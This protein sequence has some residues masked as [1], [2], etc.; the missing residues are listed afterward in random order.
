VGERECELNDRR[1]A[2]AAGAHGATSPGTRAG[3]SE[4]S[5][6]LVFQAP[7]SPNPGQFRT[8]KSTEL[9]FFSFSEMSFFKGLHRLL[10]LHFSFLAPAA[11]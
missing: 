8:G 2:V 5:A 3:T 1:V 7:N 10:G 6:D 9:T 11:D 4:A